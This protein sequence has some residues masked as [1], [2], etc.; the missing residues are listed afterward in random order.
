MASFY[1]QQKKYSD[2]EPLYI[3]QLAVIRRTY[4][5]NHPDLFRSMHNLATTYHMMGRYAEAERLYI[6]ALEGKRRVLGRT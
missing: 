5:D 1:W 3:Q 2:A 6:E 4:G